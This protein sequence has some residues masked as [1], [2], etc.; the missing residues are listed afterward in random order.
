[1]LAIKLVEDKGRCHRLPESTGSRSGPATSLLLRLTNAAHS[2]GKASM[3]S[4]D[5]FATK[6]AM[7]LIEHGAHTVAL[8][9]KRHQ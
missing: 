8:V 2:Q 9:K 4:S 1:M 7:Q 6:S 3:I 5:F